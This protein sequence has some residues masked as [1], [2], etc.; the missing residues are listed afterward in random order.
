MYT[1]HT[2]ASIRH[3]A[4]VRGRNEEPRNFGER[5]F[6]IRTGKVEE[7]REGERMVADPHW[8]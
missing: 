2:I 7:L 1:L 3:Y 5:K 8:S 6:A 4:V